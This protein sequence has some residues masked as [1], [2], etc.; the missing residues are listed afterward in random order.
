[1]SNNL[2]TLYQQ[3]IHLSRYSRWDKNEERRESY[4]ETV[5]R[6]FDFFEEHTGQDIVTPELRRYLEDKVLGLGVMP[7]MR[8]LMTAG[9]ALER[10]NICGYNCAYVAVD[11]IRV[12]GESLYILVLH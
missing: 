10:D 11:H 2:P 4:E 3:Y 7:S 8:C 12:F 1:M 6:Y 5:S 9:E